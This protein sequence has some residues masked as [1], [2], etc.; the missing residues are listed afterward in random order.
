MT[1][2]EDQALVARCLKGE[3]AAWRELESLH[4]GLMR[5]AALSRT[6]DAAQA[7]EVRQR[8]LSRLAT[9]SG[10]ALGSFRGRCSLATWLAAVTLNEAAN[11]QES[12]SRLKNRERERPW[13]SQE[14]PPPLQALC[15][16]EDAERL[17]EAM[18]TLPARDRLLLTLVYWDRLPQAVA[19]R[20]LGIHPKSVTMLLQRAQERLKEIIGAAL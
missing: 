5:R 13:T 17:R 3:D 2:E 8:V 1:R 7:E 15:R 10:R 18:G 19:A 16:L 12:E 6:G 11:L 4:G 9:D 20:T 14:V